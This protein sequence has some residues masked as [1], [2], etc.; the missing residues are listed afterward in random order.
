MIK[1]KKNIYD[2]SD[3][4]EHINQENTTDELENIVNLLTMSQLTKSEERRSL[5]S[6]VKD[7]FPLTCNN[8][9]LLKPSQYI[10]LLFQNEDT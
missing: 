3:K 1:M 6:N 8:D 5:H 2:T 7:H 4:S 9:K 10:E